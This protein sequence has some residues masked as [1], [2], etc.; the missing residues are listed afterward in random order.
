MKKLCDMRDPS[1]R[2]RFAIILLAV[3]VV[4]WPLS[5]LTLARDEPQFILG[6]SWFALILTALNIIATTDVRNE[7]DK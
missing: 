7:Q 4:G 6:L 2:V 5:A 1:N 3:C